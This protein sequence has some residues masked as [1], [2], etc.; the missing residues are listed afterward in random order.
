MNQGLWLCVSWDGGAY[1]AREDHRAVRLGHEEDIRQNLEN[2]VKNTISKG[3]GE[4]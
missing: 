1:L 2:P 3:S 4:P